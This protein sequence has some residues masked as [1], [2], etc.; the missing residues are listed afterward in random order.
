MT[1]QTTPQLNSVKK[2]NGKIVS[3][4][5]SKITQA[6]KK[7]FAAS[8]QPFT[9]SIKHKVTNRVYSLIVADP[10]CNIDS[11]FVDIEVIQNIVEMALIMEGYRSI[12]R[13]YMLYRD[14]KRRDRDAKKKLLEVDELSDV[15]K[16]YS[17]DALVI[18]KERYLLKG[19]DGKTCERLDD[20]FKRVAVASGIMEVLYDEKF[21]DK[22]GKSEYAPWGSNH[23]IYQVDLKIIL[24]AMEQMNSKIDYKNLDEP[25]VMWDE[26][27]INPFHRE[28]LIARYIELHKE[29]K[30]KVSYGD[31]LF[32]LKDTEMIKKHG[33]RIREYYNL[34]ANAIFLS[35]T[36]TLMNAGTK[37]GQLS[38][39]F[40]LPIGDSIED[41][42]KT[43]TDVALIF[44]SGGGI[45]INYDGLRPRG[46]F[47]K[48]TGGKS[49]GAVHFLESIDHDT[50]S[51]SQGGKR[52]GAAMGILSAWHP[53]IME[54]VGKKTKEIDG[55]LSNH[56]ISVNFTPDFFQAYFNDSPWELTFKGENYKTVKAR[57]LMDAIV[58][59]AHECGD[60]GCVFEDNMNNNNLLMPVFQRPIKVTNPCSEISMY[61]CDSCN[62]ASID[63]TKFVEDGQFNVLEFMRVCSLVTQFLDGVIDAN[64]YTLP[65]INET[66]KNCRR[67]GLGMMGLGHML[68][69][70][71]I[72]YNTKEGFTMAE[73]LTAIM[74]GEALNTSAHM[75][76]VKGPFPFYNDERYEMNRGQL[77]VNALLN[78]KFFADLLIRSQDITK[79]FD[80]GIISFESISLLQDLYGSIPYE[81]FGLRNCSV[82]TNA[83]TGTLSML[84][85]T[86]MGVEPD[87]SL[88]FT[89]KVTIGSFHYVNQHLITALRKEGLYSEDLID[90]IVT[91]LNG[92]IGSLK[93][94]PEHI[95]KAFITSMEIH[96]FDHI[97]MQA[98]IQRWIT[99]GISKT[100]NAPDDIT[101]KEI[102]QCYIL[103]WALGNKGITVY[104]DGAKN[105]QVLNNTSIDKIHIDARVS[106]FTKEQI[107]A[108]E[109]MSDEYKQSI[110]ER[111]PIYVNSTKPLKLTITN[112]NP[113]FDFHEVWTE[114]KETGK[115]ERLICP[116][117]SAFNTLQPNGSKGCQLCRACGH[118]I[119]TCE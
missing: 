56:N 100:I 44:K 91:K 73:Y 86:S 118:G 24:K 60:P 103:S 96:P 49:P 33:R 45:G 99:N 26:F 38:A 111:I 66:S 115:S 50:G 116:N 57:D 13:D 2:R 15:E 46:S 110:L 84:V 97:M 43:K 55:P 18:F 74:T 9:D 106:D 95:R 92:K 31:I 11:Q 27:S 93:E 71:G 23:D 85:N 36:P 7:A 102:E 25:D 80:K 40:T 68:S 22:E 8:S 47:I 98:I 105:A 89:K 65:E 117:C 112:T 94:I 1:L 53:D 14:E 72:G 10:D 6:I 51:I 34:L 109:K 61:E 108:N 29:N 88:G 32:A 35:N 20:L 78:P 81:E 119:G 101:P 69:M 52:R 21:Y 54:F 41:I 75:A 76:N 62:L 30:M 107:K 82:T 19:D 4:D 42:Y 90:K 5:E 48:S 58:H 70:L 113:V 83:P 79:Y 28:R 59:K 77:P 17:Y 12:A 67:I 64:K 37:L 16:K 3:F 63:M 104:R 39:C 114:L 87:F